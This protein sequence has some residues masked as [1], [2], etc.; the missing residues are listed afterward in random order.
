MER[1]LKQRSKIKSVTHA[2][3]ECLQSIG[4]IQ[5]NEVLMLLWLGDK[6]HEKK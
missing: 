5:D 1:G 6:F 2:L 4:S 3:T